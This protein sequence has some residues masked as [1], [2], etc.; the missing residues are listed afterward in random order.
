VKLKRGLAALLSLLQVAWSV[1]LGSYQAFAEVVVQVQVQQPVSGNVSPV[2]L[3]MTMPVGNLAGVSGVQ[4]TPGLSSLG[5]LPNVASPNVNVSPS[6]RTRVAVTASPGTPSLERAVLPAAEGTPSSLSAVSRTGVSTVRSASPGNTVSAVQKTPAPG[7]TDLKAVQGGVRQAL[8][9]PGLQQESPSE[10]SKGAGDALFAALQGEQLIQTGGAEVAGAAVRTVAGRLSAR[11]FLKPSRPAAADQGSA[12]GALP[13]PS[14]SDQ[15][16]ST[17]FWKKASFKKT[18]AVAAAVAAVAALPFLAP[19]AGTVAAVGSITLSVIGIPQIIRNF[20]A[21]RE[22][23]KD[24]V[25]ASP[26]IWFAAA[27]LLSAVSIGQGSN[28]WWNVA[29]LA[30]VAESALVVGQINYYKRDSKALKTSLLTAA[31]VLAPIPL[32]FGQ[33][34]MPL[35]AWVTAAFTA[36]MGLLWVL[37]WPQIRQNYRLYQAEGR[38]PQGIAPLYPALVALGSLLHLYAAFMGGDLR[39]ALNAIIAIVTA[40]AVLGQI[41]FPKATNAV[42]GPLVRLVDRVL[43]GVKPPPAN[44][45]LLQPVVQQAPATAA[46]V[47]A[48]LLSRAQGLVDAVFQG[49]DLLKFKA[50]DPGLRLDAFLAKAKALPGRS[51]IILEAPTAAGKSTLASGLNKVLGTRIRAIEVD[52]Y[53]KSGQ[54]VPL[55]PNGE[56]DFDRPEALDLDRVAADIRALLAGQRIQLPV[57]DMASETTR[58]DSG[59]FMELGP[60]E[61]LVVDSIYASHEKILQAAAGRQVLNMY[62]SAPAVVRLA[63]R[64]ARDKTVRGA[65]VEKNLRRWSIILSD[66][67]QYILPL[68]A[69]ADLVLNLMSE[70]ELRALP[71]AYAKLLAQEWAAGR[72][73]P[74]LD[75]L[76]LDMVRESL[77]ADDAVVPSAVLP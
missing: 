29:N 40:G 57:H 33:F 22:G 44:A 30:G 43:P 16:A 77:R 17:P 2:P 60:D 38:A 27:V 51:L 61:V 62:L 4:L 7:G 6:V 49:S 32:M 3:S 8:A 52:R 20:K 48:Q 50:V 70:E 21:G 36:A 54:Q 72:Q 59:E 28:T 76:F 1:S 53:F 34:L 64:L 73:S 5:T 75:A 56:P 11:S 74:E 69:K 68:A 71:G 41:Y 42:V 45:Q 37:N 39:W 25:L 10:S 47:D 31:S 19:Y 55:G 12:Q 15:Q 13:A 35:S 23:V 58:Y 24:L 63:R 26:L 66:E 9:L 65:P 14:I 46:P 67:K 18:A